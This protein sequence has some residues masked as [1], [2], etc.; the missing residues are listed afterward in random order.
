MRMKKEAQKLSLIQKKGGGTDPQISLQ[1][2]N[3]LSNKDIENQDKLHLILA[4]YHHKFGRYLSNPRARCL[5]DIIRDPYQKQAELRDKGHAKHTVTSTF[6]SLKQL[7]IEIP[8]GPKCKARLKKGGY[9]KIHCK[10]GEDFCKAHE[11]R[12]VIHF[13]PDEKIESLFEEL[14]VE[15]LKLIEH[16]PDITLNQLLGSISE[17]LLDEHDMN[18]AI[19]RLQLWYKRTQGEKGHPVWI[20]DRKYIHYTGGTPYYDVWK[21]SPQRKNSRERIIE[22]VRENPDAT[23]GETAKA[24]GSSYSQVKK[25][26]DQE[27]LKLR[28]PR[29]EVY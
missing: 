17:A 8:K 24:A 11:N 15:S 27:N 14:W 4:T 16:V 1:I 29:K 13:E 10:P 22:Y 20:M 7:E 26:S 23:I 18:I 28:Q 19:R 25:V 12:R 9:C 6:K 5:N 3:I 2:E 21:G